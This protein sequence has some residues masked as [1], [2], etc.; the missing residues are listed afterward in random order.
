LAG[1]E[2]TE[3][4]DPVVENDNDVADDSDEFLEIMQELDTIER[5]VYDLTP[6]EISQVI[7]RMMGIIESLK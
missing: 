2:T 1:L 6:T 3:M 4:S 7:S 5:Y